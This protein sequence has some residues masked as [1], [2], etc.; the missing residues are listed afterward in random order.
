[1]GRQVKSSQLH[2]YFVIAVHKCHKE[3]PERKIDF[4]V[5]QD[6]VKSCFEQDSYWQGLRYLR[7]V[8]RIQSMELEPG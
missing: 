7:I 3:S 4:P 5:H 1:M 8:V 2:S 6:G